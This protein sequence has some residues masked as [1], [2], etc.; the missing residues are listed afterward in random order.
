MATGSQRKHAKHTSFQTRLRWQGQEWI[1]HHPFAVRR[2]VLPHSPG[3]FLTQLSLQKGSSAHYVIPHSAFLLESGP[4]C[5]IPRWAVLWDRS[6]TYGKERIDGRRASSCCFRK[7]NG[8]STAL[9]PHPIFSSFT[10]FL[11]LS[12][13]PSLCYCFYPFPSLP[14]MLS[15]SPP[16]DPA[17]ALCVQPTSGKWRKLAAPRSMLVP[18]LQHS[19]LPGCLPGHLNTWLHLQPLQI[20]HYFAVK[21]KRRVI[22]WIISMKMQRAIIAAEQGLGNKSWYGVAARAGAL[23]AAWNCTAQSLKWSFTTLLQEQR[24]QSCKGKSCNS[25]WPWTS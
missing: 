14:R 18:Q 3:P 2:R 7:G 11:C 10:Q 24:S 12:E 25:L 19:A 9:F 20:L 8:F 21:M 13:A 15:L 23:W 17:A 1:C 16:G 5:E 4:S 22:R 6:G